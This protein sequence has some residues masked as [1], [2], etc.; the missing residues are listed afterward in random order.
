MSAYS[1]VNSSGLLSIDPGDNGRSEVQHPIKILR[2]DV[3]KVSHPARH[4]LDEPDV[5]Y[6]SGQLYMAHPV[7][8]H[9]SARHLD[10]TPLADDA[11]EPDPL[12]LSAIALP[13]L[14]RTE[15]AL[16]EEAI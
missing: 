2:A 12:V 14:R 10:A 5:R 13:V 4:A 15:D 16:A 1:S 11:L 7:A 8:P 3:Q 6:R 9:P